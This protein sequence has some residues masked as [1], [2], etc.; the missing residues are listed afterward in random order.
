ML[1]FHSELKYTI[2]HEWI[3]VKS[4]QYL[5]IG[6]TD[7]AQSILGDMVFVQL[8]D[9]SDHIVAGEPCGVI[10]SV[11]AAADIYSPINGRVVAINEDIINAPELINQDPYGVGW[12]LKIA[13]ID[14]G[15]SVK[16]LDAETYRKSL[17]VDEY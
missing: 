8:P 7:Y 14:M 12:L 11:K 10:E 5:T 6:I 4:N 17:E 2:T 9:I 3:R 13:T 1:N 15:N 16:L